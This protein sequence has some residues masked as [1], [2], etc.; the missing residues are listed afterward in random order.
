[1]SAQQLAADPRLVR[2]ATSSVPLVPL[3][4][5]RW[6]PRSFDADAVV[7]DRALTALLEAARWAPSASNQQPRRFV[8]GRRGTAT[9]EAV[10]SA[11]LGFNQAWASRASVLVVAIAEVETAEGEVRR[12]AE[13][14]LGLAVA[15]LSVQAHAEGLHTHQMGGIDVDA[16]RAAFDLPQRLVPVTVVA[17]GR[18]APAELLDE[19]ATARETAE[20]TRLPL[21]ELVLVRE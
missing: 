18:V 17:V 21:E 2:T 6:S 11:L 13:H 14:D 19:R 12:W 15:A 7:D 5:E 16:L 1:M 10:L 3:L 4:A 9:F 20:R 8:V